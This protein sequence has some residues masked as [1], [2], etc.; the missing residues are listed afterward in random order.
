MHTGEPERELGLHEPERDAGI[1]TFS[2]DLAAVIPCE[3]SAHLLLRA[4]ELNFTVLANVVA[5]MPLEKVKQQRRKHVHAEMT[6]I[7]A[8]GES[9]RD[10]SP[11]GIVRAGLF[12]DG[13]NFEEPAGFV[14]RPSPH[15]SEMAQQPGRR[16]LDG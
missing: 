12:L 7:L 10:Q 13:G 1:V 4:G 16:R 2:L 3:L 5:N 11:L 9:R 15:C 8:A 14:E 6:E